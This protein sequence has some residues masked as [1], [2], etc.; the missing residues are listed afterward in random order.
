M[1]T[2]YEVEEEVKVKKVKIN[3]QVRKVTMNHDR[4]VTIDYATRPTLSID[5]EAWTRYVASTWDM[6]TGYMTPIRYL[7]D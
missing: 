6:P 4:T 3:P 1:L 2:K 5:P 7:D